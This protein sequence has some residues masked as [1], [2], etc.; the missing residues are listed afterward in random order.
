MKDMS[1]PTSIEYERDQQ[2]ISEITRATA[3]IEALTEN[4]TVVV[5][6]DD[7]NTMYSSN[8]PGTLVGVAANLREKTE[9]CKF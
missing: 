7:N 4:N 8:K 5:M 3:T 1:S 2:L 9:V 6:Q